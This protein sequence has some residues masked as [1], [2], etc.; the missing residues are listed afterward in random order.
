MVLV[1]G[2]RDGHGRDQ[3]EL[4]VRRRPG[5]RVH[6]PADRRRPG[7]AG[8]L[9]GH[10]R[11]AGGVVGH[12]RGLDPG[13]AQ[14]AGPARA[15]DE[16]GQPVRRARRG[17]EPRVG[18][19]AAGH[20]GEEPGILDRLPD[21]AGRHLVARDVQQLD[22]DL[23][24][25]GGRVERR[26]RGPDELAVPLLRRRLGAAGGVPRRSVRPRWPGRGDPGRH[27]ALRPGAG[28]AGRRPTSWDGPSRRWCWSPRWH[29]C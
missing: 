3:P 27:A 13:I 26:R 23:P 21:V 19:P 20:A 14:G 29:S 11:G 18:R 1:F 4:P 17:P 2:L 22:A 7:L 25:P 5:A 9:L 16:P 28:R 24:G 15:G 8:H 6:G 10:R 12:Q